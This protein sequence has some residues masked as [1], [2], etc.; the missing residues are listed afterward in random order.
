MAVL[1]HRDPVPSFEVTVQLCPLRRLHGQPQ[2]LR[3]A[4]FQDD[5]SS[6]GMQQLM[7]S[8]VIV[9]SHRERCECEVLKMRFPFPYR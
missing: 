7:G 1:G 3:R 8:G 2:A 9:T 6:A 5:D 4:L